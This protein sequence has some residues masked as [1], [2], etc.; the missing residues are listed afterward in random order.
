MREA[1]AA[2]HAVRRQLQ[3]LL[4]DV[5]LLQLDLR[6]GRP[7]PSAQNKCESSTCGVPG[8]GLDQANPG[9]TP[10]RANISTWSRSFFMQLF[11]SRR[12]CTSPAITCEAPG[13]R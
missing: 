10:G 13:C 4:P 7:I 1:Q 3:R 8:A 11:T 5:V 9:D 2:V 6:G 12:R